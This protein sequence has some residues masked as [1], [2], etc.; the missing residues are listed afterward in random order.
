MLFTLAAM[1]SSPAQAPD[2]AAPF[3]VSAAGGPVSTDVGHAHPR[4]HDLDGDGKRDL[5]VGQFGGGKCRVYRNVG[6]DAAPAFG[7]LEWLMAGD[8][9]ASVAAS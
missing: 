6:T 9:P 5:L 3:R 8:Q 2:L 4:L 1:L 7:E